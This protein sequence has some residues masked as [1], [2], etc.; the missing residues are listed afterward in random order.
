MGYKNSCFIGQSASEMTNSQE[1][2]LKFLK[3]K[4]WE[5]NSENFPFQDISDILIKHHNLTRD[6]LLV[7]ALNYLGDESFL[8]ICLPIVSMAIIYSCIQKDRYQG[9]S[10]YSMINWF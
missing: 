6:M 2:L 9:L 1:S 8:Q 10:I 3:M 7:Q 4:G 5:L